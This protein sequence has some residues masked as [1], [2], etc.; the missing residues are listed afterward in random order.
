VELN[1]VQTDLKCE[2]DNLH[3]GYQRLS[4]KHK[5][6]NEKVEQKKEKLAEAHIVELAILCGDLDLETHSYTEYRQTVCC[7]VRELHEMVTS[8]FDEV[9]AQAFLS[10]TEVRRWKK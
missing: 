6:L 1:A 10:P 3:A 7:R 8:S 2:R 4:E 5:V 9:K